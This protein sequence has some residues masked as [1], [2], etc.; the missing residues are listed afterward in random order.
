MRSGRQRLQLRAPLHK[1]SPD[2]IDSPEPANQGIQPEAEWRHNKHGIC[3]A[4]CCKTRWRRVG[5]SEDDD[6]RIRVLTCDELM[7]LLEQKAQEAVD[8]GGEA[9]HYSLVSVYQPH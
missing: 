9:S 1:V 8:A 2:G 6:P 4:S 3:L 5:R 7:A